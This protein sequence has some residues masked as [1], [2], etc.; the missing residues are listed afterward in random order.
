[1]EQQSTEVGSS[2]QSSHTES[3][4]AENQNERIEEEE[5]EEDKT[6]NLNSLTNEELDELIR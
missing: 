5:V 4:E 6:K 2:F 1:M 3:I